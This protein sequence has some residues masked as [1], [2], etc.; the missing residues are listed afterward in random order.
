[1]NR[2]LYADDRKGIGTGNCTGDRMDIHT[3]IS[4]ISPP[5]GHP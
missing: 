4:R 1:M 2:P 5:K 3:D